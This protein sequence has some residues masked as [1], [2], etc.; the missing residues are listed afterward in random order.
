MTSLVDVM[1]HLDDPRL[2]DLRGA[3]VRAKQAGV[4]DVISAGIH[5]AKDD[6]HLLDDE[7]ARETPRLWRAYGIHP[8]EAPEA[9]RDL[10]ALMNLL[11]NRLCAPDVVALGECGLDKRPDMPAIDAQE[12]ALAA[13][14]AVA[15]RRGL[16]VILHCVRAPGRLL[17]VIE[18]EGPLP[19][20]GLLHGY[21][22]APDVIDRLVA[23]NLSFSFGHIVGNPWAKRARASARATPLERLLVETDAPEVDPAALLHHIE[24]LAKLR[25]EPV[26]VIAEATARNARRLFGLPE[27]GPQLA[28][29]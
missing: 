17:D 12:R 13:Q 16:P 4:T 8:Q 14:L 27:T 23:L 20:G 10:E 5:P 2:E 18:R 19:A 22:G 6:A 25:D 29:S 28:A 11:E 1:C 26:D 3:L 21:S 15:R 9:A 24:L 7:H